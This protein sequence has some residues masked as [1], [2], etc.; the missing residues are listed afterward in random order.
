[1]RIDRWWKWILLVLIVAGIAIGVRNLWPR[2]VLAAVPLAEQIPTTAALSTV[3]AVA[4]ATATPT[5]SAEPTSTAVAET[6]DV[7]C[8]T[9]FVDLE[10]AP[11]GVLS[12][13]SAAL[14][15]E[16]WCIVIQRD[17]S[18][19]QSR[20]EVELRKSWEQGATE[21]FLLLCNRGPGARFFSLEE[22]YGGRPGGHEGFWNDQ[23]KKV[24]AF[25][26]PSSDV[27]QPGVIVLYEND[28]ADDLGWSLE[29]P[30]S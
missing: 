17:Q 28:D 1:M 5:V 10:T 6:T 24:W 23:T 9:V 25:P 3:P 18:W 29:I 12:N 11:E 27:C 16:G 30:V 22:S 13:A 21:D 2:L 15:P 26:D 8:E 19:Q 14:V 7:C 4:E 20:D